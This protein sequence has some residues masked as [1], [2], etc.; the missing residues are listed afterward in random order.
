[1]NARG[2]GV[3]MQEEMKGIAGLIE[4]RGL[5]RVWLKEVLEL[6][7]SSIGKAIAS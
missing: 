5:W 1:M 7:L 2:D 3:R 4:G 6:S